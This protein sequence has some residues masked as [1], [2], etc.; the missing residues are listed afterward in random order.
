[1]RSLAAAAIIEKNKLNASGAWLCLLEI[2]IPS[3]VDTTLY[4]VYNNEDITW[5]S[6]GG[7]LYQAF[8]FEFGDVSE[9]SK[10]EKP[11]VTIRVSNATRALESYLEL[12]N[13]GKGATVTVRMVHSDHLDATTAYISLI[14]KVKQTKV[15]DYWVIFTLGVDDV[16]EHRIPSSRVQKNI[17]RYR[18]FGGPRC[19]FDFDLLGSDVLTNGDFSGTWDGND[20]PQGHLAPTQD[21]NNYLDK[22]DTNNRL[23][24]VSLDSGM[25]VYQ[26]VCVIGVRYICKVDI[27][28]VA[29]GSLYL[30]NA[31]GGSSG[32]FQ[33]VGVHR[34]DFVATD[35]RIHL[36]RY[37]AVTDIW[38]SSWSIEPYLWDQKPCDRSY[39]R[40]LELYTQIGQAAN[41]KRFGGSI[42]VGTGG[43]II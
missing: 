42:G 13:G 40:C 8:P 28:S 3:P 20:V 12:G 35:D 23:R 30:S 27:Y 43:I 7:N 38:V 39:A 31:G 33:T 34:H 19:Q 24:I 17:C 5:P 29:S 26:D 32:G 14:F 2:Y 41:V 15:N 22:D 4:L 21:V 25:G 1:M 16:H 9:T 10:N 36:H 6:A 11:Q 18:K 37:A